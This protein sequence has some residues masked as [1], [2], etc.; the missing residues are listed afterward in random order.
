ML[1]Y[2]KKKAVIFIGDV[3][4][5]EYSLLLV[6]KIEENAKFHLLIGGGKKV[7]KTS[8]SCGSPAL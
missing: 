4:D 3:T 6:F 8:R 5:T 1:P 7:E 2:I